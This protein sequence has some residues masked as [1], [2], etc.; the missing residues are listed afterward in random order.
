MNILAVTRFN[1]NW[2]NSYKIYRITL[3]IIVF[4][5]ITIRTGEIY[6]NSL[7]NS[8]N[9]NFCTRFEVRL[10]YLVIVD[11]VKKKYIKGNTDFYI[12][13]IELSLKKRKTSKIDENVKKR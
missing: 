8:H 6:S 1:K 5:Y 11:E 13:I 2:V 12:K 3:T 10:P 4:L 7:V 9:I